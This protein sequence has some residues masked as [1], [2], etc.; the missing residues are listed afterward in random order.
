[1]GARRGMA[2]GIGVRGLRSSAP[3]GPAPSGDPRAAGLGVAGEEGPSSDQVP[4]G[5]W[6]L[7]SADPPMQDAIDTARRAAI[8][9]ATVLLTGE[10][11]TGKNV[12]ASAMHAWSKRRAGPFVVISCAAFADQRHRGK[13]PGYVRGDPGRRT[14]DPLAAA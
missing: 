1:M 10:S 14:V 6:M 13:I 7:E 4:D 5:L 3:E 12:L 8:S 2:G 9:D 11:G